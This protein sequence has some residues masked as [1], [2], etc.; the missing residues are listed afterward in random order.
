VI[1]KEDCNNPIDT[2]GRLAACRMN[3]MCKATE[4]PNL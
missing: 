1:R 3:D 2:L 4:T